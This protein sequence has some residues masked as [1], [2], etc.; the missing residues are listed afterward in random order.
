MV[1]PP[2]SNKQLRKPYIV[3]LPQ[4]GTLKFTFYQAGRRDP[5]VTDS[6]RCQFQ[7]SFYCCS[8]CI[9]LLVPQG[10]VSGMLHIDTSG[11]G[12][13]KS[14]DNGWKYKDGGLPAD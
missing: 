14:G 3:P 7:V 2:I 11:C 1:I 12:N 4:L 5:G 9:P 13:G 8:T 6:Q 10:I